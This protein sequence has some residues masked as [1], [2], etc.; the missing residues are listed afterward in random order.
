MVR[1][2]W[3]ILAMPE[4]LYEPYFHDVELG[5]GLGTGADSVCRNGRALQPGGRNRESTITDPSA[6]F[7]NRCSRCMRRVT[8]GW[9]QS[10][11]L[12]GLEPSQSMNFKIEG[13]LVHQKIR[14]YCSTV[15]RKP[16]H[17]SLL[18]NTKCTSIRDAVL[19]STNTLS[20][21]ALF[22]LLHLLQNPDD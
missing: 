11:T 22:S 21:V 7:S 3:I 6:T 19:Y 17:R 5:L 4:D 14:G 2:N 18:Y 8:S 20:G 10:S 9:V 1:R 15:N 12:R 16:H 13:I